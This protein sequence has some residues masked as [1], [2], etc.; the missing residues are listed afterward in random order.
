M[1]GEFVDQ[2]RGYKLVRKDCFVELVTAASRAVV[3]GEF[4][5]SQLKLSQCDVLCTDYTGIMCTESTCRIIVFLKASF[6][7]TIISILKHSTWSQHYKWNVTTRSRLTRF[8]LWRFTQ[9]QQLAET[10]LAISLKNT[11]CDCLRN[12]V[13]LHCNTHVF[14]L[15]NVL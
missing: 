9:T 12:R 8:C 6:V 5:S 10:Y 11:V 2:F 15:Q 4:S 14:L 13:V 1:G 3:P 7:S